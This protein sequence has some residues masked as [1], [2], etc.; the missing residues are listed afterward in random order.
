MTLSFY[1]VHVSCSI[2]DQEIIHIQSRVCSAINV[3]HNIIYF[4]IKQREVRPFLDFSSK[5]TSP[6][7]TLNILS[8]MKV[9]INT[10]ILPFNPRFLRSFTM[11]Y[12]QVASYAFSRSK[13]NQS[14]DTLFT[15]S[16]LFD[17]CF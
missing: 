3:F 8:C 13:K 9:W 16:L 2:A 15:R 6:I 17:K 11:P 10:G 5:K 4:D 14:L 7:L 12:F 1:V